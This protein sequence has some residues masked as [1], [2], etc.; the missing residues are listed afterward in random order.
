M[1]RLLSSEDHLPEAPEGVLRVLCLGDVVGRPG[2]TAL[3]ER[4][5]RLR[6]AMGL[7]MVIANGENAA[8]GIGLTPE[9]FKELRRSGVD[10]VT[11]GNHI[12]KHKEMHA[13]LNSFPEVLR[14]A[15]YGPDAPGRGWGLFNLACGAKVGVLNL[16]GRSFMEP[17]D[18]PFKA[19]DAAL[20]DL[21]AQGADFCILDFHAEATSEK[22]A[23]QHYLDGRIAAA[24]GTHTHV[25]TADARVSAAGTACLTDLGM[26]G[27]EA[28]S[29][30]G[31]RWEAVV[32]RFVSG[33]PQA[34]SPAKGRGT[35]NGAVL[36]VQKDSGKSLSILPLRDNS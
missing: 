20:A 11:S 5:P 6:A 26:C 10:V 30:L 8:G 16:M 15:N 19:A 4:L 33:L 28:D 25:Q 27:V 13:A 34:F 1:I 23:M 24:L 17:L 7:H 14:P 3:A 18:C 29:V 12:W 35:L 21:A 32:K 22:R 2:R 31:M 9:T 36:E